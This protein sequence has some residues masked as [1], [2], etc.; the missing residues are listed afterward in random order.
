LC[1]REKEGEGG[2]R[3]K[4]EGKREGKGKRHTHIH[5]HPEDKGP[6]SER[7]SK[8]LRKCQ[9]SVEAPETLEALELE[10]GLQG[11]TNIP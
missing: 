9:K 6:R 7:D 10:P 11:L 8:T 2:R 1:V 4:G 5:T 3:G